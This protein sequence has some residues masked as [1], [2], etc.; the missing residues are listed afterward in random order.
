MVG[1]HRVTQLYGGVRKGG[2][3]EQTVTMPC[4]STETNVSLMTGPLL[5]VIRMEL[6]VGVLIML[7]TLFGLVAI[8]VGLVARFDPEARSTRSHTGGAE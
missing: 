7:G 8:V 4:M 1:D 5:I 3:A 6:H 2:I